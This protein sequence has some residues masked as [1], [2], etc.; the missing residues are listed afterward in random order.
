MV[1]SSA[2]ILAVMLAAFAV[3]APVAR[4]ADDYPNRVITVVVP[5]GAGSP[6][7]IV[8]RQAAQAISKGLNQQ[9]IVE[10][11][12]GAAG[13]IGTKLVATA[14]AD[15]YRLLIITNSTHAANVALFKTLSY[16]PVGD[17]TPITNLSVSPMLLLA[18][19]VK[20]PVRSLAELRAYGKANPKKLDVGESGAS[21]QIAASKLME[22]GGFEAVKVQYQSIPPA[23]TDLLGGQIALTFADI[24]SAMPHVNGGKAVALGITSLKRSNLAP[25]VP[26]LDEAGLSGFDVSGWQGLAA[27]AKTPPEVIARIFGAIKAHYD[28]P[29]VHQRFNGIGLQVDTS[30]DPAA[31][32]RFI[33]S[34]T[35]RWSGMVRAA[36]IEPQ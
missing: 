8:G 11:R 14:P 26:T 32:Q 20:A 29:D 9:V 13:V 35:I 7:D 22:L 25:D 18:N 12:P 36:G 34:E 2:R 24:G 15:G 4:A 21:T 10:N 30:A 31:Y 1:V 33:A 3:A 6:T 5:F 19:P 27:P 23:L 16:D 28:A 17:F